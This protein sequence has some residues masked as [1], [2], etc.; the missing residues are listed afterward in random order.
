MTWELLPSDSVDKSSPLLTLMMSL[1][2]WCLRDELMI[3]CTTR[4]PVRS[5]GSSNAANRLLVDR[6]GVTTVGVISLCFVV[7][8]VGVVTQVVVS[9]GPSAIQMLYW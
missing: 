1:L 7:L 6:L 9:N 5:S 2:F 8:F 4:L 3:L